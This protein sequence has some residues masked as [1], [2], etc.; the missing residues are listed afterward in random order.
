[1]V[2]RMVLLTISYSFAC[3]AAEPPAMAAIGP[4]PNANA[5]VEL[6]WSKADD[7]IALATDTRA[8]EIYA[9]RRD[10]Q[11]Q[12]LA[13]DGKV[14]ASVELTL[15]AKDGADTLRL[16][17]LTG[18]ESPDLITFGHWG[19]DV[20]AFERNGR[21]LW[22][23]A[24]PQGVNDV[25]VA[26]VNM[27]E[28]GRDEIIIGCNGKGGIH[29]LNS[30]STL[31]WNQV[32]GNHWSATSCRDAFGQSFVL[33][34]SVRGVVQI[35]D[36]HGK[37]V[38]VMKIGRGPTLVRTCTLVPGGVVHVIAANPIDRLIT[39]VDLSGKPL[40]TSPLAFR[41]K[42]HIRDGVLAPDEP[43]LAVTALG[44]SVSIVNLK[45]GKHVATVPGDENPS[46]GW[47]A[48]LD[49]SPRMLVVG[50]VRSLRAYSIQAAQVPI[51]P[52]R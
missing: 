23:Y 9:V 39:A 35:Y 49:G 31:L 27:V 11:L 14:I 46:V 15:P 50:G 34:S 1:M 12:R 38:D 30:N 52:S 32:I 29:V 18:D 44:E 8:S 22:H 7:I 16:A 6:A 24:V 37:E 4:D 33:S 28:D 48:P 19:V 43:W 2:T 45:N 10:R 26:D 13:R 3:E 51:A 21:Q 36:S 25:W 41:T 20:R 17:N 47:L 42:A 5:I 40:W